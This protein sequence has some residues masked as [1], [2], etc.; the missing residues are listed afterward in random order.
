MIQQM[1]G[2]GRSR[3]SGFKG[4]DAQYDANDAARYGISVCWSLLDD[5]KRFRGHVVGG[6]LVL[7]TIAK[8]TKL[9]LPRG[10]PH[11]EDEGPPVG[12][13]EQGVHLHA[14]RSDVLLLKL[15]LQQNPWPS[16]K[17]HPPTLA[18][19]GTRCRCAGMQ[20]GQRRG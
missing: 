2:G 1:G 18:L 7:L 11:V 10:I 20:A 4:A 5:G 13:E 15:T 19:V 17:C 12:V 6:G 14:N 16:E 9:L 8:S 3:S